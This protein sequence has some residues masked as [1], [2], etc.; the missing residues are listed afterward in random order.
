[1]SLAEVFLRLGCALVSWVV[2]IAYCV[3]L[4]ALEQVSCGPNGVQPWAML[5]GFGVLTA[6]FACLLPLGAKVPGVANILRLPA[7][8]LVLLVPLAGR[9]VL[10]IIERVNTDGG[11]ICPD[12]ALSWWQ[13]W[14]GPAQVLVLLTIVVMAVVQWRRTAATKT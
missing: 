9:H 2:I 8:T 5:L 14:W 13:T 4:A 6:M 1:M 10:T 3:W 7:L 12:T 11:T